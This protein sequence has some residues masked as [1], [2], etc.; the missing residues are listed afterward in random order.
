MWD[1]WGQ[2]RKVIDFLLAKRWSHLLLPLGVFRWV[3]WDRGCLGRDADRDANALSPIVGIRPGLPPF[4]RP[5]VIKKIRGAPGFAQGGDCRVPD[6]ERGLAGQDG[7]QLVVQFLNLVRGQ[8]K[9]QIAKRGGSPE[10]CE[11]GRIDGLK[12]PAVVERGR[13]ALFS[14]SPRAVGFELHCA[15]LPFAWRGNEAE[16]SCVWI[17]SAWPVFDRHSSSACNARFTFRSAV[18]SS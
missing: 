8:T 5:A 7:S 16:R 10:T 9:A 15:K 4:A 3:Q 1:Q 6:F 18:S 11:F 13:P 2:G 12:G 14:S 17:H